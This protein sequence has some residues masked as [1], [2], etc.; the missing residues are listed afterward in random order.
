MKF[1]KKRLSGIAILASIF[2][3]LFVFVGID[4]GWLTAAAIFGGTIGTAGCVV[5]GTWLIVY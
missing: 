3:G 1:T 4:V 2:I 5:L